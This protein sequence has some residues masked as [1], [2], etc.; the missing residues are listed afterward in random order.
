VGI[1]IPKVDSFSYLG[2]RRYLADT[3][4]GQGSS[5]PARE[6]HVR[7]VFEEEHNLGGSEGQCGLGLLKNG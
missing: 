5:S 3:F 4:S 1:C 7:L 6:S 2:E